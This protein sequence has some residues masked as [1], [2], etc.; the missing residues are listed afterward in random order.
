MNDMTDTG[1]EGVWRNLYGRHQGKKLRQGQEARMGAMLEP[2]Q[3]PGVMRG[4][5]ES[6]SCS[7]IP[8]DLFDDI[9]EVWLE[10]GF[11][12][13]E[14]LVDM[15]DANPDIGFIGCE[16]F[17]P[18]VGK[19]LAE[20]ERR[21]LTN[22]R[23]HP[24]DARDLMASLPR[25]CIGQIFLL[26]PDPWPKAR[27][28][29]R[30]FICEDNLLAFERILRPGGMLRVASDIPDY[31]DWTLEQVLARPGWRWLAQNRDEAAKP[32]EGWPGTRYEA[33]ALREGRTPAYLSFLWQG[34][35]TSDRR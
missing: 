33:K 21:N 10:I 5:A 34:A 2:L 9:R 20:I 3:V 7:L 28:R 6:D 19:C 35:R 30:R 15:A 26:Y 8:R 12:G 18:G 4:A 16:H 29:K 25:V 31:I 14:H 11:G 27:H 32:W 1:G 13:G 17:V 22:V 23:I 24:Q